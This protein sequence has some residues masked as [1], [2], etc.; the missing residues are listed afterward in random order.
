M[1]SNSY[2]NI[3]YSWF[4][5]VWSEHYRA[6]AMH[7]SVSGEPTIVIPLQ[8]TS[9]TDSWNRRHYNMPEHALPQLLKKYNPYIHKQLF[10][11]GL[12]HHEGILVLKLTL[13]YGCQTFTATSKRYQEWEQWK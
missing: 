13:L 6:T 1:S 9:Y 12:Y 7:T 10:L 5:R 4:T 8:L 11:G 3:S 2:F